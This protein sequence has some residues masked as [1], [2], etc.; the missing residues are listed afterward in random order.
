MVG[1]ESFLEDSSVRAALAFLRCVADPEDD[2]HLLQCLAS[3][4]F[5]LPPSALEALREAAAQR[6]G[7]RQVV[8]EVAG[9]SGPVDR[10]GRE[11]L[12]AFK[13]V[14]EE[15]RQL[16]ATE[17]PA[18]LLSRWLAA[19]GEETEPLRR[20]LRVATRFSDLASFLRGLTLAQEADHDRPG[21]GTGSAE[22]VT[23]MT[24]HAAKGL[25]FP[26]VFITGVED[27]LIPLKGRGVNTATAEEVAEERRLF[28]VALTRAKDVLILVSARS[29]TLYGLKEAARPSPFLADIPPAC[30]SRQVWSDQGQRKK[31]SAEGYK[32]L[33]LFQD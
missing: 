26:V 15:C 14:L 10:K 5:A 24:M 13:E 19:N 22:A 27:G 9:G 12:L 4:P 33:R 23:L 21:T 11:R 30:L 6:T 3:G 28:Y 16:A 8:E 2:F 1:W 20:L 18:A 31:A 32:Q 17:P 7:I 25:E 29:R